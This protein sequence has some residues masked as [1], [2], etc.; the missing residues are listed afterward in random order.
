VDSGYDEWAAARTPSLL[1]FAHALTEDGSAAEAAVRATLRRVRRSWPEVDH[2]GD[3]DLVARR[4]VVDLCP[5]RRRAAV[6]LRLL[7][8]RSDADIAE[9]LGASHAFARSQV[10]R[11]LTALQRSHPEATATG[12]LRE[13]LVEQADIAPAQLSPPPQEDDSTPRRSRSWPA[14]LAVLALL[15]AIPWVSHATRT[16]AGTL[17]YPSPHVPDTWRYESYAGVQLRVPADWGW[18]GAPV[19]SD[20]FGGRHLGGCG[21]DQAAVLSP[22]DDST[23]VTSVTPFVGRPAML[24]Q[25]CVTWGSAG[26]MPTADAVWFDSP[27]AVGEKGMGSVIAE[28]RALGGQHVTV[29]AG[30]PSL[31]REILGTA[32]TVDVD[33]HGCPTAAVQQ[34][35]GVTSADAAD[36]VSVC[37][38]SQDTGTSVLMWSGRVGADD[39]RAYVAATARAGPG[40]RGCDATPS[41]RWVALGVHLGDRTRWD[42][43]DLSCAGISVA[44][45][46]TVPMTAA[47]VRGWARDGVAAYVPVP[48][49]RG[50]LAAYFHSPTG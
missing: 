29:F 30:Q 34:P 49:G 4:H 32:E 20:L 48:R 15:V 45:A 33:A 46:G 28:T 25:R 5:D 17:T 16:T 3:P 2:E 40:V 14:V 21:A 27:L 26:V 22:A 39:A 42:V 8:E 24:S 1:R 12:A 37:V 19:H 43:V 36:S 31:R 13:T 6:V 50:D 47:T 10:Q 38:Y 9:V 18:G 41:G 35:R 44:G 7:E 11:G 23:Y